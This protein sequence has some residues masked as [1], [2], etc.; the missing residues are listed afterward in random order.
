MMLRRRGGEGCEFVAAKR[1]KDPARFI[2]DSDHRRGGIAHLDPVIACDGSP[3]RPAQRH[4]RHA[5]LARGGYSIGRNDARIGMGRVDQGV[6]TLR[7]EIIGEPRGAAKATDANWYGMR[8]RRS[9]AAGERQRD[10][11]AAALGEAFAQ[12]TTLRCAAE[13]EDA[14]HV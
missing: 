7:D 2:S 13:N 9:R 10:I 1:N 12:Q 8:H 11:E 3:G 6:D 5:G 14:S 4:E